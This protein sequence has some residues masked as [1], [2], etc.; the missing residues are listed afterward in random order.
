MPKRRY[1]RRETLEDEVYRGLL[2]ISFLFVGYLAL[3]YYTNR[4]EF[5][6]WLTY[7]I[8]AFVAI[9]GCG[10]LFAFALGR[11]RRKRFDGLLAT[12]RRNQLDDEVKNFITRFGRGQERAKDAWEY[13]GYKI[14]WNRINEVMSEFERRGARLTHKEFSA[15]L[16]HYIDERESDFTLKSIQSSLRDFNT[17]NGSSFESL[18]QRLYESMGYTVQ[19]TG[20]LATRAAIWWR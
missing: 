11:L 8:I 16:K 6:T 20:E 1:Y 4:T 9:I 18:L 19:L 13:R 5:W 7:G 2:G 17:L 12:I 14:D 3:L 15:I 10:L